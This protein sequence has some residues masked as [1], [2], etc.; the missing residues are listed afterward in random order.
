M[1]PSITT[2]TSTPTF[3][4]IPPLPSQDC[5]TLYNLHLAAFVGFPASCQP[6][7]LAV[8]V[9]VVVTVLVRVTVAVLIAVL[10]MVVVSVSV[11]P[12]SVVVAY[13][14]LIAVLVLVTVVTAPGRV[15]VE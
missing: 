11:P 6:S 9:L 12:G 13:T 1:A 3:F 8:V 2:T 7:H 5:T 10:V 4:H 14:V 15:V